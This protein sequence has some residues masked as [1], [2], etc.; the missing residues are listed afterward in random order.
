LESGQQF[1]ADQFQALF[2]AIVLKSQIEDQ[3]FD[4]SGAEFFDLGGTIIRVP[5]DQQTFQVLNG[6]KLSGR[7]LDPMAA[8]FRALR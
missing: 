3:M 4:S 8:T 5:Y 2:E 1:L 6:L 7:G